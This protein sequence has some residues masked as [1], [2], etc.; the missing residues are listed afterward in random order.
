MVVCGGRRV[1]GVPPY[2]R[3]CL[4]K[5][6]DMEPEERQGNETDRGRAAADLLSE[7]EQELMHMSVTE[8]VRSMLATLSRL[9]LQR[10]GMDEG[11]A[12]LKDMG[13]AHLAIECFR[14]LS[15]ALE[16]GS[17]EEDMSVYR[18]T[19]SHMQMAFVEELRRPDT[20]KKAEGDSE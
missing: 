5:G 9:A 4:Q 15:D 20:P 11:G 14:V 17:S 10:L 6:R 7:L 8:H 1:A 13:Q 2:W 16:A 12:E 19:L 18:E 3:R